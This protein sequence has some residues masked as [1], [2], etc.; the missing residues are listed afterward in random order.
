[1][2]VERGAVR[3]SL[4]SHRTWHGVRDERLCRTLR[5]RAYPGPKRRGVA[6]MPGTDMQGH[7]HGNTIR[8]PTRRSRRA[9]AQVTEPE[10][11][12]MG[13]C[14]P[15]NPECRCGMSHSSTDGRTDGRTDGAAGSDAEPRP[16]APA[17]EATAAQSKERPNQCK[18]DGRVGGRRRSGT[19]RGSDHGG[20]G[21]WGSVQHR[22]G[23][24]GFAP[25]RHTGL[26]SRK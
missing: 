4:P 18:T 26:L 17:G 15:N 20:S 23:A 10:R 8:R 6:D 5:G 19:G 22:R 16:D 24:Q 14:N 7:H 13:Q 11:M 2:I 1:M 3:R 21:H 9:A 25:H 12:G